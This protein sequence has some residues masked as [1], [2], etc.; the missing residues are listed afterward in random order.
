M[1]RHSYFIAAFLALITGAPAFAQQDG[2]TEVSPQKSETAKPSARES[3]K[4]HYTGAADR[5]TRDVVDQFTSQRNNQ[6]STSLD[7]L[8][9]DGH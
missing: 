6:D 3:T 8:M 9:P 7:I 2:E 1:G 5:G 4:M